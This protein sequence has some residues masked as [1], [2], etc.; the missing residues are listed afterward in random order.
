MITIEYC[1]AGEAVSDFDWQAWVDKI[2]CHKDQNLRW[3]VSTTLP[4]NAVRLLIAQDKL[5]TEEV[6]FKYKGLRVVVN[7]YGAILDW[8]QGFCMGDQH[9]VEDILR[10]G[11]RK[12]KEKYDNRT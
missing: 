5:N 2:M 12:R 8:P 9:I 11:I 7:E 4:I 10:N 6:I 1:A 3:E